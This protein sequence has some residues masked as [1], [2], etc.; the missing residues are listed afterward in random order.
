MGDQK[1]HTLKLGRLAVRLQVVVVKLV[2]PW[3]CQF[4]GGPVL[5]SRG[6]EDEQH[7]QNHQED[8]EH[9][10]VF[11]EIFYVI[12]RHTE[13]SVSSMDTKYGC[14]QLLFVGVTHP[15]LLTVMECSGVRIRCLPVGDRAPRE[16]PTK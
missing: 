4:R 12:F 10:V 15:R 9:H 8:H 7:V 1:S 5:S 13:A 3:R 6:G 11:E 16:T 2:G 14:Y